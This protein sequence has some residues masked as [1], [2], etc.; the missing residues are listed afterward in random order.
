MTTSVYSM[1]YK[2]GVAVAAGLVLMAGATY[3]FGLVRGRV[4]IWVVD[5]LLWG[6]V[7]GGILVVV[8]SY[9][10]S[11]SK[12]AEDCGSSEGDS[13][14]VW[15]PERGPQPEA[16]DKRPGWVQ[17]AAALLPFAVLLPGIV[18][19]LRSPRLQMSFH[20]FLHSAYTYQI[21]N[22]AVPPENPLLPGHP[23]ND[24]W[25][26]HVL[27]AG[28]VH[29]LRV[30]PPL[31]AVL[32]NLT[33]LIVSAFLIAGILRRL[34]LW[35]SSPLIQGMVLLF[36]LF[37]L[38]LIGV[39]NAWGSGAGV[40]QATFRE[41]SLAQMVHIGGARSAGLFGKFLNFNGFPV[42]VAF[43]LLAL[44]SALRLTKRVEAWPLVG[45]VSG[46][47]G[48]LAFHVTTGAF[49]LAVLPAALVISMLILRRPLERSSLSRRRMAVIA[50]LS[51]AAAITLGHY[52]L[53]TAKALKDSTEID[54]L[55]GRNLL[56][57]LLLT[58]PLIPFFM[59]GIVHAVRTRR[60]DL[61]LLSLATVG[62]AILA[63]CLIVPGGNQY[64]FD[65]LSTFPMALVALAGWKLLRDSRRTGLTY[66]AIG[67]AIC[68]VLL[69]LGNQV[70]TSLSYVNSP[71]ASEDTIAYAGP[72]VVGGRAA[73]R[74]EA[75]VWLRK[76]S[77]T[78]AI[79]V[80]P[81]VGKDDAS[82]LAISQRLPYAIRGAVYTSGYQEFED[83]AT[84]VKKLYS[85][86][87]SDVLKEEVIGDVRRE[88]GNRP[89]FIVVA[90]ADSRALNGRALGLELV[91]DSEEIELFRV[92]D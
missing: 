82:F 30:A 43:F 60:S 9:R 63:C 39:L 23:A 89:L 15:S 25:L 74:A 27:I 48:A 20:G 18:A 1:R 5:V 72:N 85:E 61:L 86:R 7:V 92:G 14:T 19:V 45:F 51:L 64:K 78:D 53:V 16:P 34:R 32:L 80:L 26:F 44:S 17:R 91:F 42:G 41:P 71:F 28:L 11:S 69:T 79:V 65:Y 2:L 46:L 52:L 84:R 36:V 77:P 90:Q 50:G 24:Y 58:A 33:A 81:I 75:W 73:T 62:G 12:G 22:G 76:N 4:S 68:A 67:I 66:T 8:L 55:N 37:A 56:R 21:V 35:P 10:R 40:E 54:L 88:M 13:K 57:L 49:A 59:L 6:A 3:V 87:T 83:R 38:N 31:V 47:L 29:S 70:Y